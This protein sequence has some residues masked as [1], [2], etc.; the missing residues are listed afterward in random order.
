MSLPE[1]WSL[2]E[3]ALDRLLVRLH[4]D[5]QRAGEEYELL[6]T[7]LVKFFEWRDSPWP[8]EQA[9]E[10]LDRLIR[11]LGGSETIENL[12]AFAGGVARL[13]LLEWRRNQESERRRLAG[14]SWIFR[15]PSGE[16]EARDASDRCLESCLAR[17][18][19]GERELILEYYR[20]EGSG[21][22][23]GRRALAD[24]LGVPVGLLRLRAH[25]IRARIEACLRQC[26]GSATASQAG[27]ARHKPPTFPSGEG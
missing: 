8:E 11:R 10:C 17:L 26:L 12:E 5:R 21:R 1:R 2:T 9:D 7:R 6:R 22:I 13:V 23:A 3:V 16:P 18:A 14:V 4:P 24:R 15:L 25:R 20:H 19:P 27:A